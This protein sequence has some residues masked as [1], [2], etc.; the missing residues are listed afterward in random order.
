M[1]F[2]TSG[3]CFRTVTAD[4]GTTG[5]M[6][7]SRCRELALEGERLCRTGDWK[8]GVIHLEAALQERCSEA[9]TLCFVYSQLGTACF[10]LRDYEKSLEYHRQDAMLMKRAGD[11]TGEAKAYGSLGNVL[12]AVG[13]FD[14]AVASFHRQLALAQEVDDRVS[15]VVV[16]TRTQDVYC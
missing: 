16:V 4:V 15:V 2:V 10:Y 12:K 9:S 13:R 6:E 5:S 7:S 11:R 14:E 3:M 8:S 1:L